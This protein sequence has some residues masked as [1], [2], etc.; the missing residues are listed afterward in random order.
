LGNLLTILLVNFVN[1][2][3]KL[4]FKNTFKNTKKMYIARLNSKLIYF[5]NL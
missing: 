2:S 1:K 5:K 3:L 4:V